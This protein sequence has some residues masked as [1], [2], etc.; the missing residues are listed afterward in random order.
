MN[1]MKLFTVFTQKTL[2]VGDKLDVPAESIP[3]GAD[4]VFKNPS[5]TLNPVARGKCT[6][7]VPP[8]FTPSK[9]GQTANAHRMYKTFEV[10]EEA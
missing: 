2:R 4:V 3:V 10:T 9:N 6:G 1:D 5:D 7:N 8:L